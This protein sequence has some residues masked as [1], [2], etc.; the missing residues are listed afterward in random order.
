MKTAVLLFLSFSLGIKSFSQVINFDWA[1]SLDRRTGWS[2]DETYLIGVDAAKNVYIAGN[3]R[4]TMDMDPGPPVF[5][6]SCQWDNVFIIKLD[7]TGNFIWG[8]QLGGDRFTTCRSLFVDPAGNI[9]TT[10][11]FGG[12]TDF[13]PGPGV[14]NLTAIYPSIPDDNA[15]FISKLDTDG[16]FKWAKQI[17]GTAPENTGY[18]IWVD[19]LGNVFTTGYFIGVTDFDPGPGVFNLG[20]SGRTDAFISKLDND[21]NFQFAKIFHGNNLCEGRYIRTD[22]AGNIYVSG[23][24]SGTVDFDPG[25]GVYNLQQLNGSDPYIC[26]LD[27]SGNFIWAKKDIGG[28]AIAIDASQNII[29]F[30]GPVSKYDINGDPVWTK[31]CGGLPATPYQCSNLV[32]DAAGNIYTSGMFRYTQDFDPGPGVY[33][34][35]SAIG[36]SRGDAFLCRWDPDGNFVWAR[37]FGGY[38]DDYVTSIAVDAS[39]SIYSSGVYVFTVDFDPGP[40]VYNMTPGINGGGFFIHKMSRCVNATSAVMNATACNSYTL[41]NTTYTHSGT[42]TQ[43]LLNAAGCDSLITL[44]LVISG[45]DSTFSVSA[46]DNYTWHNQTYTAS[47]IYNDTIININGCDSILRLNLTIKN[48]PVSVISTS[49][50]EG[51]NYFG[52]SLPGVYTDNFTAANGCDSTRT[53]NLNVRSK[54]YSSFTQTICGGQN[55]WGHTS[56]GIYVDTLNSATGCDSLRTLNLVV[57]PQYRISE[58]KNICTGQSYAGHSVSGVYTD[59]LHSVA[60][61]DSIR[62]L[63]LNVAEKPHPYLG[64]GME[65]CPGDSVKLNPGIFSTYLWQD[66]FTGAVFTVHQPGIYAVTVTNSCGGDSARVYIKER[67]CD[68]YFPT[69]FTPNHDG[70]NDEFKILNGY[71]LSQYHLA[72]YNRYGQLIFET[73]DYLKGWT[74]NFNQQPS[75]AGAYPWIC[76]YRQSGVSK[77]L[78]GTIILL[79]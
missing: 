37:S 8:K 25:P 54:S 13:D 69:A 53:V 5:S 27:P 51:Q 42:Y 21:G 43:S 57:N 3:F 46:C 20:V 71:N 41:N 72:V 9:Y 76:T 45:S 33:T 19:P 44:H 36:A 67:I 56:T 77:I 62:I 48:K 38:G 26:K 65:L 6:L 47:G 1:K 60:G 64:A 31:L 74:G 23:N 55:Y 24:F 78:K 29:C 10:G 66:G 32:L 28:G 2:F 70:K 4:N 58:T 22:G 59:S 79:R 15:I 73:D 17:G 30:N 39:G 11:F 75:D 18:S 61:C 35:T 7:P 40:G 49:I 50:C 34:M 12:T 52:H 63:T 14:F 68:I 16:N